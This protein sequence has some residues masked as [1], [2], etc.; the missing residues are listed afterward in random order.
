MTTATPLAVLYNDKSVL[1]SYHA[2]A[3]FNLLRKYFAYANI[4][5]ES[6]SEYKGTQQPYLHMLF[7]IHFFRL[8]KNCS[9]QHFV[10]RY[11]MSPRLSF[12][13]HKHYETHE[14]QF[15]I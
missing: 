4:D 5:I 3:F 10:Y 8:S 6:C 14:R 2:M 12:K 11:G 9:A 1:E 15:E 7:L 13:Y